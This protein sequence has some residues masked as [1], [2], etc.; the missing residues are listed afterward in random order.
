MMFDVIKKRRVEGIISATKKNNVQGRGEG[1]PQKV[2]K[3]VPEN[4]T[5]IITE[6]IEKY[7]NRRGC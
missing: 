3:C 1:K 6:M 2:L 4:S 5:E 7:M